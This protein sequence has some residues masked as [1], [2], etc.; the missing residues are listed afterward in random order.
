MLD[1]STLKFSMS[2]DYINRGKRLLQLQLTATVYSPLF[3]LD[4][5]AGTVREGSELREV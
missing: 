4:Q 2:F 3:G 1:H 5:L